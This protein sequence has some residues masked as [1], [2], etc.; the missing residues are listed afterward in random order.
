MPFNYDE[1][2]AL[3]A[4]EAEVG[5]GYENLPKGLYHFSFNGEDSEVAE[6]QGGYPYLRL[7]SEIMEGELEGRT[8]SEFLRW[9]ANDDLED[10]DCTAIH[11]AL[12]DRGA[13]RDDEHR[14]LPEH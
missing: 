4:V 5:G 3:K 7:V 10:G 12:P 6:N 14:R 9:W 8:H 1:M 2:E 11:H 13:G